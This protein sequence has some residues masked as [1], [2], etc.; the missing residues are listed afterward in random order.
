MYQV[1][2]YDLKTPSDMVICWTKDGGASGGTGQALRI[3]KD[4]NIPIYNL[5]NTKDMRELDNYI[6]SW[7]MEK[8]T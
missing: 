4:Y 8:F 7:Q 3:A 1:L 2:G 5:Y 6:C